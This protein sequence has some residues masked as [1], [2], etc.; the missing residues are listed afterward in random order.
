MKLRTATS[1]GWSPTVMS[2]SDE[3]SR[4][5]LSTATMSLNLV[6]DE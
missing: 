3:K 2:G 5:S 6:I 1:S 4:W